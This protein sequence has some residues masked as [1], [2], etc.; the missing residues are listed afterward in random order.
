MSFIPFRAGPRL[1]LLLASLAFLT[2]VRAQNAVT[3]DAGEIV[4]GRTSS[5]PISLQPTYKIYFGCLTGPSFYGIGSE[6]SGQTAVPAADGNGLR[7]VEFT[8]LLGNNN[9]MLG[10]NPPGGYTTTAAPFSVT[11]TKVVKL[12]HAGNA[13]ADSQTITVTVT[14]TIRHVSGASQTPTG[15]LPV[16]LVYSLMPGGPSSGKTRVPQV[17]GV[18][19]EPDPDK[20]NVVSNYP[21]YVTGPDGRIYEGDP[22]D[23]TIGNVQGNWG[24]GAHWREVTTEGGAGTGWMPAGGLIFESGGSTWGAHT[25]GQD[26]TGWSGTVNKGPDGTL[27]IDLNGGSYGQNYSFRFPPGY[28]PE[29]IDGTMP[30]EVT[31]EG[32]VDNCFGPALVDLGMDGGDDPDN[33]PDT[34]DGPPDGGKEPDEVEVP[35]TPGGGGGGGGGVPGPGPGS[36]PGGS[37]GTTTGPTPSGYVPGAPLPDENAQHALAAQHAQ[38]TAAAAAQVQTAAEG[39]MGWATISP[40]SFGSSGEWVVALPIAGHNFS[41]EIPTDHAP[42]IRQI[43]LLVVT[44]MFVVGCFRLLI[45]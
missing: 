44:G 17:W 28:Q 35:G 37:G 8:A 41:M 21:P 4:T 5:H 6:S 10:V 34:P 27:H 43:L 38:K 39:L 29:K 23:Y 16:T 45:A 33:P 42:L 36:Q 15:P 7:K 30:D 1:A 25:Q 9:H 3:V 31:P 14:G 12:Q 20:I 2:A 32:E 19:E 22:P 18:P 40:T 13:N 11:T 26:F 24:T